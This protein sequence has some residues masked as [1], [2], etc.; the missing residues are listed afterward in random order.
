M[1]IQSFISDRAKRNFR[2]FLYSN[3]QYFNFDISYSANCRQIQIDFLFIYVRS[4]FF[5]SCILIF[6]PSE[7]RTTD[8]SSTK[9]I[10][11]VAFYNR[12]KVKKQANKYLFKYRSIFFQ[13]IDHELIIT[14]GQMAKKTKPTP[15][16][17]SKFPIL[18]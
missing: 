13:Q 10:S 12:R 9:E 1:T 17:L 11:T 8:V 15:E 2:I 4:F 14:N 5:I 6:F 3:A 18:K 16:G 7:L